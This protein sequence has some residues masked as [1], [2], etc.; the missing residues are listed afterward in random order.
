MGSIVQPGDRLF[1]NLEG[2]RANEDAIVLDVYVGLPVGAVPADH[3]ELLAGS[4]GLFGTQAATD[5]DGP[6]GGRGLTH[7]LDVTDVVAGL[8]RSDAL[9]PRALTVTIVPMTPLE[10]GDDVSVSRISVFREAPRAGDA[11]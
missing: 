6:H 1:L 3:P 2:L 5:P 10:P 9:D 4:I 7:V 11:S 8:R